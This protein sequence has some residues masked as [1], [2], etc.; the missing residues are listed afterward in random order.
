MC[1]N[2]MEVNK[3]KKAHISYI[4]FICGMVW[5]VAVLADLTIYGQ[6]HRHQ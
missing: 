6:I 4:F 3:K 1:R 5:W 2:Q